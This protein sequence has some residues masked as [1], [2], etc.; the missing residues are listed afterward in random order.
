MRSDQDPRRLGYL[1]QAAAGNES[2]SNDDLAAIW[3]HQ[4]TAAV[5]SDLLGTDEQELGRIRA[6]SESKGLLIESFRD[7]LLHPRPPVELLTMTKRFAKRMREARHGGPPKE[8]AIML[9][10]A[11]AAA[12]LA[13]GVRIT[14]LADSELLKGFK[15]A[16]RNEWIDEPTRR[17]LD[18]AKMVL[19]RES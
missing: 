17:L 5:D 8:I 2:W 15:W 16:V 6:E 10:Y 3:R 18:E 9:Y 19:S 4:L 13:S 7:L 1:M 14:S 11:A 12:A